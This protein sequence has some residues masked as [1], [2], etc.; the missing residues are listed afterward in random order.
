MLFNVNT[1]V[2]GLKML[3]LICGLVIM[4]NSQA[5]LVTHSKHLLEF[6]ILLTQAILFMLL[7]VG[8][9]H[10][11][12]AFIALIG[13]SLNL[14]V[15]ILFD[16]STHAARE[17]GIKYYYLS[18]FSSGLMIYGMFLIYI[19]LNT[20]NFNE[21]ALVLSSEVDVVGEN[22]G[23]LHLAI[24]LVLLGFSFKLSAFPG[25]L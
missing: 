12:S 2:T 11:I 3:T 20:G 23:L 25:H 24:V 4:H 13:F 19:L 14:Y 15:L 10:L 16:A 5:Y 21:I 6:P 18:T 9:S 1:Y 17:A 22:R 8:S 7:L